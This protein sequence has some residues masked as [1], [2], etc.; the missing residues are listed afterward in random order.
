MI[1]DGLIPSRNT[2]EPTTDFKLCGRYRL[3]DALLPTGA[4]Y[5]VSDSVGVG[6]SEQVVETAKCKTGVVS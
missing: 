3:E 5:S 1:G 4:L 2:T 6:K